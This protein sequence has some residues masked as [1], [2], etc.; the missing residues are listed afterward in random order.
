MSCKVPIG[1]VYPQLKNLHVTLFIKFNAVAAVSQT[2]AVVFWH[3]PDLVQ[4]HVPMPSSTMQSSSTGR[5]LVVS[6]LCFAP[7]ARGLLVP[8]RKSE[9]LPWMTAPNDPW[10]TSMVGDCGFDPLRL[11]S[12]PALLNYYR[13]AELK[14]ARL[15][16]LA[17]VGWPASELW[18]GAMSSVLGL[19][20]KLNA[21]GE[22][23]SILNGGLNGISPFFWGS[24]IGVGVAFELYALSIRFGNEPAAP[25]DLKWDPLGMFP[26]E[27]SR[28]KRMS[29]AELKHG[30]IAMMAVVGYAS[31]EYLLGTP[32]VSHSA[33]FF[34]PFW[35][36]LF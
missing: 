16:M 25:G 29:L 27:R 36:H 6:A 19:E 28:Q 32:I 10:F 33:G 31:E 14:H 23:P 2:E 20:P 30:R 15:A 17:A 1:D 22:A 3:T 35:A 13:E 12:S 9:A 26:T 7:V 18:D 34:E 5:V 4:T 21:L 11:A 8:A 24:A